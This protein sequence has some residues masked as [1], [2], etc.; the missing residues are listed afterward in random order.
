MQLHQNTVQT[1]MLIRLFLFVILGLGILFPASAQK[2][3]EGKENFAY[4]EVLLDFHQLTTLNERVDLNSIQVGVWR[5]N[6]ETGRAQKTKRRELCDNPNTCAIKLDFD[7]DYLL[8]V[9]EENMVTVKLL[10]STRLTKAQEARMLKKNKRFDPRIK[11]SMPMVFN[12]EGLSTETLKEPFPLIYFDEEVALFKKS[13]SDEQAMIRALQDLNRQSQQLRR[14]G[15]RLIGSE[16]GPKEETVLE[17][18]E[19]ETADEQP[20]ETS[21]ENTTAPTPGIGANQRAE[22]EKAEE[23]ANRIAKQQLE[24]KKEEAFTEGQQEQVALKKSATNESTKAVHAKVGQEN[25]N[26]LA[27]QPMEQRKAA[28]KQE[29]NRNRAVK[30]E[31]QMELMELAAQADAA[32]KRKALNP[33]VEK[34]TDQTDRGTEAWTRLVFA[35]KVLEYLCVTSAS[36]GEKK[37][38]CNGKQISETT[39]SRELAPFTR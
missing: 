10:V 8:V 26:K 37:Y 6:R 22:E 23:K 35:E 39:Y 31:Q 38:Y 25:E 29:I 21:T 20:A 34:G 32:R 4:I 28:E 15:N 13:G 7:R 27:M 14:A 19:E 5:Y 18:D 17:D 11:I 33:K 3:K 12:Y 1:P 9:T 30:Q 24:D 16:Q 2:V 36:G